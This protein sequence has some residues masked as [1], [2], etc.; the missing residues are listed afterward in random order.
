MPAARA[1]LVSARHT[2]RLTRM[3]KFSSLSLVALLVAVAAC[4]LPGNQPP[5]LPT[6]IPSATR[7][8]GPTEAPP[9]PTPEPTKLSPI[10]LQA[11]L[12][13]V[14]DVQRSAAGAGSQDDHRSQP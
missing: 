5:P 14:G 11:T 7:R 10:G 2:R 13:S 4:D 9:S 6:A 8:P 12:Q 1:R 3:R